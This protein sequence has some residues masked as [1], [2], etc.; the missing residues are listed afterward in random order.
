MLQRA[1]VCQAGVPAQG[2]GAAV[3]GTVLGFAG[4]AWV[5]LAAVPC[6]DAK[7]RAFCTLRLLAATRT[8]TLAAARTTAH[9][10]HELTLPSLP[11][12]SALLAARSSPRCCCRSSSRRV[13]PAAWACWRWYRWVGGG[14]GATGAASACS[15]AAACWVGR[16]GKGACCTAP[17]RAS[18]PSQRLPETLC[19][20]SFAPRR[21]ARTW[22]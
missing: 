22:R 17:L 7:R 3:P 2:G 18:F 12:C 21:P 9:P 8:T 1:A 10:R 14:L 15:S 5:A 6:S 16:A 4:V 20:L 19:S 11:P 13:A